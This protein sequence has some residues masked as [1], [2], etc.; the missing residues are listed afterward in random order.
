M[1]L[2]HPQLVVEDEDGFDQYVDLS[3]EQIDEIIEAL[4]NA[5]KLVEE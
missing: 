5:K 4:Q 2:G 3:N 1:F